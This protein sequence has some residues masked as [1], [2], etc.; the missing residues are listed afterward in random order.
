VFLIAYG[1]IGN[2]ATTMLYDQQ[3]GRKKH[4]LKSVTG[5]V[6]DVLLS[7][8]ARLNTKHCQG[9]KHKLLL[10]AFMFLL[11]KRQLDA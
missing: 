1:T 6:V 11:F 7:S 4:S 3:S 10:T 2:N 8:G 5:S 9:L